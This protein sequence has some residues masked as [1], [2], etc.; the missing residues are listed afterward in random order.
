M[1][2]LT[3]LMQEQFDKMCQTGMLFRSNVSG[4]ELWDCGDLSGVNDHTKAGFKRIGK[5][6]IKHAKTNFN[7]GVEK[8]IQKHFKAK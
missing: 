1:K 5:Y 2:K 7:E 8:G 4:Q 6:L 3:N